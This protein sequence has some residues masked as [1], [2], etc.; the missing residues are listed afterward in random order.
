MRPLHWTVLATHVPPGGS[1]GGVVRYTTEL[2]RALSLR[3]DV[4][5]TA[6]TTRAAAPTVQGL[7]SEGSRVRSIPGAPAALL[8]VAERWGH[9]P[10]ASALAGRV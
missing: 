3:D 1:L 7:L 10:V 9:L 4:V 8:S 6:V 2:I 5:V